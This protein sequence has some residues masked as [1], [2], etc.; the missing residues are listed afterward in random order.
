MTHIDDA[1]KREMRAQAEALAKAVE[2]A[3]LRDLFYENSRKPGIFKAGVIP[4]MIQDGWLYY[5]LMKPEAMRPEL[6]DPQFQI[7]KGTREIQLE[8]VWQ[9]YDP[10]Q[11]KS[12]GTKKNLESLYVNA[13]RE[14][15]E[16][17]GLDTSQVHSVQ[18]WGA[19]DFKS[20]L[21][22]LTK[23]M[24]LFLAHLPADARFVKPDGDHAATQARGWFAIDNEEDA[25]QIR[26]DHL[27]VLKK[28]EP[29]LVRHLEG[30]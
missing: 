25:A 17:L 10:R 19:V 22:G 18:E 12:K 6:G 2:P 29:A 24:W 20:E 11:H 3:K 15:I 7:A 4:Y 30:R 13:I 14:G 26:P 8:G 9:N 1:A 16:E 27:D 21:T 5:Y 23:T 28:V